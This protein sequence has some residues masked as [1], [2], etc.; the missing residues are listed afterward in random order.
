[1]VRLRSVHSFDARRRWLAAGLGFPALLWTNAL[2]AQVNPPVV[3]GWMDTTSRERHAWARDAFHEGMAALGRKPGV[4]YVLEERYADGRTER[5]PA[6]AQELAATKPAV[7]VV[8]GSAPAKAAA[9]AAPTT[10]VVLCNGDPLAGG[11]VTNLARP[12]GMITGVSNVTSETRQKVV[13]LLAEAMPK[14]RR[15]GFLIDS[16]GSDVDTIVTASRQAAERSRFEAVVITMA[17]PEDIAPAFAQ[18]AKSKVQALVILPSIW[19]NGHMQNIMAAA[20]AQRL[21]AVGVQ[22]SIPGRGGLFSFGHN[23]QAA[24]RRSASYVDRILKGAKP[25]DLPI[26]QPTVFDLVLNMKTAKHLGIM[27]PNSIRVRATAVIQ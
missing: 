3:I 17:T 11:L 25:G 22:S 27:I 15:V 13:E 1:M 18:L 9:A 2:P 6:L 7:I 24:A 12:G 23:S 14:L 5:L 26:E 19:F 20:L 8:G 4:Q 16:S 21:P 10:P